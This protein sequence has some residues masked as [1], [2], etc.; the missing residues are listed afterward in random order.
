MA[1]VVIDENGPVL[2]SASVIQLL[3]QGNELTLQSAPDSAAPKAGQ[4]VRGK[5]VEV[6]RDTMNWVL[7]RSGKAGGYAPKHL[8]R[9]EARKVAVVARASAAL[10]SAPSRQREIP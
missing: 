6:V 1:E 5:R 9:R 8:I 10:Y 4:V 7:I 3:G 2:Y